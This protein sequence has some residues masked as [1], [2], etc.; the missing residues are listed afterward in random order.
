VSST[1]SPT[2]V[3]GLAIGALLFSIISM[4]YVLGSCGHVGKQQQLLRDLHRAGIRM[5]AHTDL[6]EKLGLKEN[7]A[8]GRFGTAAHYFNFPG[9][10]FG[11]DDAGTLVFFSLVKSDNTSGAKAHALIRVRTTDGR[12][13]LNLSE[14]DFVQ[15][16]GRP[17]QGPDAIDSMETGNGSGGV[18]LFS[19]YYDSGGKNIIHV[20]VAFEGDIGSRRVLQI[21]ATLIGDERANFLREHADFRIFVP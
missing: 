19:Y 1:E 4:A 3:V 18:A 20:S 16:Y 7:K 14:E 12:D 2:P 15:V 11:V 8:M 17:S 6:N 21:V 5:G 9:G 13:I 10:G